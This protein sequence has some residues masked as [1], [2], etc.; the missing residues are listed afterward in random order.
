MPPIPFLVYFS[1]VMLALRRWRGEEERDHREIVRV[2]GPEAHHHAPRVTTRQP[3]TSPGIVRCCFVTGADS[4]SVTG[5]SARMIVVTAP[6]GASHFLARTKKNILA[7][8][9]S[10][11]ERRLRRIRS[12]LTYPP[13]SIP[14]PTT[15]R[16]AAE[17]T[18]PMHRRSTVS[19]L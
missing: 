17:R 3:C 11:V 12:L 5:I 15:R 7:R 18:C 6:K 16:P 14:S 10:G 13:R 8:I 19:K 4:E 9:R 2:G 1:F